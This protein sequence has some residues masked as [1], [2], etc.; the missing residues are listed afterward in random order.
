MKRWLFVLALLGVGAI[1]FLFPRSRPATPATQ[2][3]IPIQPEFTVP[4]TNQTSTVSPMQSRVFSRSYSPRASILLEA[5]E[6]NAPTEW[7]LKLEA[8]M[9]TESSDAERSERLLELYPQLPPEGQTDVIPH[10]TALTPDNAYTNLLTILTNHTTPELV[11]D[12][13]LT[14]LL[15]RPATTRLNTLLLITRDGDHPKAADARA[16]LTAFLGE[17]YG[18]DWNLW[19]K[20][21]SEW[22]VSHP[23]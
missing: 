21:I 19:S 6:T 16:T 15:D 4:S 18:D 9:T 3:V 8:V 13:L 11:A 7:E 17:D 20:K 22:L 10:L 5:G 2:T 12:V 23:E 1:V 14:D